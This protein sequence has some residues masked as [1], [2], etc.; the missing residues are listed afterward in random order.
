MTNP[1]SNQVSEAA[2][3]LGKIKSIKKTMAVRLNG[4]KPCHPGKKRGRPVG[5]KSSKEN[6]N[7]PL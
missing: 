2:R 4:M 3:V 1:T 5:S 6:K 7:E